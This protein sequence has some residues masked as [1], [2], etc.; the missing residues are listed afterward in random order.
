M[1]ELIT[2]MESPAVVEID[3]VGGRYHSIPPFTKNGIGRSAV[4]FATKIN[5]NKLKFILLL[6]FY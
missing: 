5:I 6:D 1:T 2:T 3:A 4:Q